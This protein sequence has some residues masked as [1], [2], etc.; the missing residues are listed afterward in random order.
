MRSLI[1]ISC[2]YHSEEERFYASRHYSEAL[3]AAG[4]SPILVPLIPD[5]AYLRDLAARL[6]GVV[7]TGS[8]SDVDP[9]RYGER[10]TPQLGPIDPLKDEVDCLLLESA[11]DAGRPLL[12]ICYGIQILNVFL[13]GTLYQDLPTARP[14]EIAHRQ[15][16]PYHRLAHGLSVRDGSVLHRWWGVT[17]C[18]VNSIHHQAIRRTAGSLEEI[19]WSPDGVVE[20][21]QLKDEGHLVL[22]VQWHPE[23][24]HD[25]DPRSRALFARFVEACSSHETPG[26]LDDV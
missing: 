17:Q 20:A 7:L 8:S 9:A 3:Y 5:R 12:G 6:S 18:E 16:E 19:A 22:G 11:F 15:G 10:P 14:S 1:G 23:R 25:R 24:N 13:G 21:V 4:A 26:P 2:R